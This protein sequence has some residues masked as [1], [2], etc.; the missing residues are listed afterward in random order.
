[1]WRLVWW[2]AAGL[3]RNLARACRGSGRLFHGAGARAPGSCAANSAAASAAPRGHG[4][5]FSCV[6]LSVYTIEQTPIRIRSGVAFRLSAGRPSASQTTARE[7]AQLRL[8]R[9]PGGELLAAVQPSSL[10][11]PTRSR[12]S[13]AHAAALPSATERRPP[14]R[15]SRMTDRCVTEPAACP[16]RGIDRDRGRPHDTA[17]AS[18]VAC[19]IADLCGRAR[20][21]RPARHPS[22]L[23]IPQ[24]RACAPNPA[25]ARLRSGW[26]T[27]HHARGGP[28][29]RVFAGAD[30]RNLTGYCDRFPLPVPSQPGDGGRARPHDQEAA[31]QRQRGDAGADLWPVWAAAVLQGAHHQA[32]AAPRARSPA[33]CVATVDPPTRPRLDWSPRRCSPT[34]LGAPP[35]AHPWSS[36]PMRWRLQPWRSCRVQVGGPV[37]RTTAPQTTSAAPRHASRPAKP[38]HPTP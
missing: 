11:C 5:Q 3:C 2:P 16:D 24:E 18:R 6:G 27:R 20:L 7:P 30:P 4:A 19:L 35:A 32:A 14:H 33:G 17:L 37:Q 26:G 36:A 38:P 29:N 8:D 25:C 9:S 28:V 12:E 1:M 10:K 31:P 21:G 34:N 13:L 23:G 22:T 15:L